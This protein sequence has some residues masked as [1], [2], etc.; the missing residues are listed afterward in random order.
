MKRRPRVFVGSSSE[1]LD[2]A[3]AF[4]LALEHT[5]DIEL[6]TQGV[7]DL[8]FSYLESLIKEVSRVDFAALVLT[9]DDLVHSRGS[10]RKTPR[11]N[12]IFEL[13]L[14]MGKLGRRRCFFIY[15]KQYTDALKLPSDLL[16]ISAATY[17]LRS[18]GSIDAAVGG[19]ATRTGTMPAG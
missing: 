15:D 14:F 9:P 1:G 3:T 17:T 7:F 6:W 13:G 19:A 4:Q 11:D 16:G 5:A 10:H 18:G 8:N 12:V 2:I